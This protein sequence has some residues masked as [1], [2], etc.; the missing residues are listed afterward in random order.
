[1]R[2]ERV[3]RKP[4]IYRNRNTAADGLVGVGWIIEY[5]H[6]E[7][8]VHF[9]YCMFDELPTWGLHIWLHHYAIR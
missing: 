8:G 9:F 7:G 6:R 5:W 3:M 4:N 2:A 1:M